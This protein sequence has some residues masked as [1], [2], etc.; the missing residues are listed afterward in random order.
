MKNTSWIYSMAWAA[1]LLTACGGGDD[2]GSVNAGSSSDNNGVPASATA[3]P[4]AFSAYVGSLSADDR[5][6]PRDI[7]NVAPSTSET[8]EPIDVG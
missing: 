2:G 1:F 4:E 5:A 6:E 7:D 3:S 8:A